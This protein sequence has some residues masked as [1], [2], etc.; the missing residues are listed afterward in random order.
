[1]EDN[2]K[3]ELND[4]NLDLVTGGTD[5]DDGFYWGYGKPPKY[6]NACP[7]CGGGVYYI[8]ALDS[9]YR[10]GPCGWL[11]YSTREL[12]DGYTENPNG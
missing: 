10:C 2:K 6:L 7:K 12:A 4:D 1:M 5:D 8:P 3:F 11:G 9:E